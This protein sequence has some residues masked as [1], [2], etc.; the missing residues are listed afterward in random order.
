MKSTLK[1][2]VWTLLVLIEF[3]GFIFIIGLA[4]GVDQD[5]VSISDGIKRFAVA[6][7]VMLAAGL[8]LFFVSKDEN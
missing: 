8:A 7:V 3:V 6:G 1:D 4:G 2:F 5:M